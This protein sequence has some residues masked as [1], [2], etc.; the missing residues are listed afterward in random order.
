MDIAH[1]GRDPAMPQQLLDREEVHAA[2]IELGGAV[3]A[4]HMWGEVVGPPRQVS[5]GRLFM[6]DRRLVGRPDPAADPGEDLETFGYGG[7]IVL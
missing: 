5:G 1:R 7:R 6:Y 3:V 4:Q 2:Q